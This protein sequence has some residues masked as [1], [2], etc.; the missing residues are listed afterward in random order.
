MCTMCSFKEG[1]FFICTFCSKSL[2]LSMYPQPGLVYATLPPFVPAVSAPIL[3]LDKSGRNHH[4]VVNF[5]DSIRFLSQKFKPQ[6]CR[7]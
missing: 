6:S 5:Y 7:I 1:Q 4:D 2:T 3:D